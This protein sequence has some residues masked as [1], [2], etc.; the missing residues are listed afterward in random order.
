MRDWNSFIE[1]SAQDVIQ[2]MEIIPFLVDE[3]FPYEGQLAIDVGEKRRYFSI[4]LL[5]CRGQGQPDF[6]LRTVVLPKADHK[7]EE[8]N[9]I[10]LMDEIVGLFKKI[11][12]RKF[13][14][15]K[16]LLILRDGGVCGEE[17]E[18]L[19]NVV[20]ELISLKFL[21]NETIVHGVDFHKSSE[22]EIRFWEKNKDA[23]TQRINV[24]EGSGIIIGPKTLVLSNTG[25]S[26]ISQGTTEPV[27]I[28]VWDDPINKGID[29][30]IVAFAV[31]ISA[32][33]NWGSPGKAQR[34]PIYFKRTDEELKKEYS[35]EVRRIS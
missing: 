30:E 9:K 8:I 3:Q 13:D 15:L 35:Q 6:Y 27:T 17:L 12:F 18:G 26:T 32:Q 14:S 33:F 31:F 28:I 24:M 19:K 25:R 7:K 1:L 5:I 22:K 21:E 23:I 34:L 11:G 2:M 4:S 29:L 20:S 10:H 16:S